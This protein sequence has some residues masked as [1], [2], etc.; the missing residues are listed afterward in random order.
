MRRRASQPIGQRGREQRLPFVDVAVD[1][2]RDLSDLPGHREFDEFIVLMHRGDLTLP[3]GG[4]IDAVEPHAVSKLHDHPGQERV[5]RALDQC[6]VKGAIGVDIG[7]NVIGAHRLCNDVGTGGAG[8][9]GSHLADYLLGQGHRVTIIDDLSTGSM[10]NIRE[11]KEN[12][13]FQYCIDTIFDKPLLAE[14][15]D[16]AEIV[17]HLAAAVGVMNIVESP[18]RTTAG[19]WLKILRTE[20]LPIPNVEAIFD[21]LTPSACNFAISEALFNADRGLPWGFPFIRD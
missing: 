14:L 8:F 21:L 13:R 16:D 1:Q 10:E 20:V 9:I 4:E 6:E 18:V 19:G 5:L 17:F 7:E 15:I 3:T 11:A 12:G 2:R